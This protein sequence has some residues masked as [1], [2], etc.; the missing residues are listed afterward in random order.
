MIS[1]THCPSVLL[2]LSCSFSIRWLVRFLRRGQ[3]PEDQV[4]STSGKR[5]LPS[6]QSKLYYL[7]LKPERITNGDFSY[8][9]RNPRRSGV[10]S[11]FCEEDL[12]S[13]RF[14]KLGAKAAD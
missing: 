4:I 10:V 13:L 1:P 8:L 5:F 7:D 14:G 11:C 6:K 12:Y 3:S 9:R 2:S